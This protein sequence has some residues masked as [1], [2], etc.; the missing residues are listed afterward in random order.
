MPVINAAQMRKGWSLMPDRRTVAYRQRT[1]LTP[2]YTDYSVPDAWYRPE[3][4]AE[5][6]PSNGVYIKRFRSWFIVKEKLFAAGVTYPAVGDIVQNIALDFD[7]QA[8]SWTVLDMDEAGALGAY[9]LRCVLLEI[10]SGLRVTVT[11]KRPTGAQDNAARRNAFTTTTAYTTTGTFQ[12]DTAE[13][14][15]DT[16]GKLQLPTRGV[17]YLTSYLG[18]LRATDT[19]LIG[20][21]SYN[22]VG[23]DNPSRLDELQSIRVGLAR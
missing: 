14:E 19:V 10:V 7:P 8:G 21:T 18:D 22:I 4:A 6:A 5:G 2:T 17:V 15:Q 12:S 13:A 3:V 9:K 23:I 11:I 16:L 20:S 1:A